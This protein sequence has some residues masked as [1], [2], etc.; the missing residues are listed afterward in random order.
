MP[1]NQFGIDMGEI[2]TIQANKQRTNI[3]AQEMDMKQQEFD[4]KQATEARLAPIRARIAAGDKTAVNEFAAIDPKGGSELMSMYQSADKAKREEIAARVEEYG[5]LSA[6]LAQKLSTGKDDNERTAILQQFKGFLAQSSPE[7]AAKI[8]DRYTPEVAMMLQ[9]GI[10]QA[11]TVKDLADEEFNT[12][13]NTAD[14]VFKNRDLALKEK[15]LS[16]KQTREGRIAG[17]GSGG[18]TSKGKPILAG[19]VKALDESISSKGKQIFPQGMAPSAKNWVASEAVRLRNAD[20]GRNTPAMYVDAAFD[21][22][23]K[24][25][26]G[27]KPNGTSGAQ[28]NTQ[29]RTVI[30]SGIDKRTGKKVYKYNDGTV[31]YAN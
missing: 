22:F 16:L 24:A 4:A 26:A 6:G 19:D 31:G 5:R 11:R 13:K 9:Q 3:L 23:Q 8:P 29:K 28:N 17:G 21:S 1:A 25:R 30:Q 27:S 20:G 18:G 7:L 2:A 12:K 14:N 10:T 15:E